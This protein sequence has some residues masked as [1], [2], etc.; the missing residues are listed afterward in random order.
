M[1]SG[2]ST[3]R[4]SQELDGLQAVAR[5]SRGILGD[6]H[7]PGDHLDELGLDP[8]PHERG[9]ADSQVPARG[10]YRPIH[11]H[12]FLADLNDDQISDIED[13]TQ[14]TAPYFNTFPPDPNYSERKDFNGDGVIDIEDITRLTP[15]VFNST[16]T[17]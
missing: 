7:A 9:Q 8:G 15:P 5:L 1:E 16:C 10:P 6:F 11:L 3:A 12:R 4:L 2:P 13:I 14:L 17:P